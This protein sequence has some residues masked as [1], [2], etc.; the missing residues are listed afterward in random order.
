MWL[1]YTYNE[2]LLNHK[3]EENPAISDNMDDFPVI[4]LDEISR[5]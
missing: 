3:K 5:T 4:M 1:V 2:M